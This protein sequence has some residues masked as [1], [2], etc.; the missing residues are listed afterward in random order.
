M[1]GGVRLRLAMTSSCVVLLACGGETQQEDV[2][3]ATE[4]PAIA[5]AASI[6]LADVAGTWSVRGMPENSDS[7]IITFEMNTTAST[8]GWTMVFEG[9]PP[10]PVQ[11][12]AVEG[13]SI[14]THAGP[15]E[16]TLRPGTNVT[17]HSVFR[18]QNGT[19]VGTTTA[20]YSTGPDSVLMVRTEATRIQ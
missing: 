14:V 15:Y 19:M 16:S 11:V 9:R 10:V 2:A 3:P 7:T 1:I 5:P 8:E 4:A 20:T 18:M 17:T 6:S 12:L 13:D